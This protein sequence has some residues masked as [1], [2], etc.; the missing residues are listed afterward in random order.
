MNTLPQSITMLLASILLLSSCNRAEET[1]HESPIEQSTILAHV[2]NEVIT[3]ED[4]QFFINKTFANNS[5][6]IRNKEIKKNILA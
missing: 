3:D 1:K 2:N 5:L 6:A 4:L